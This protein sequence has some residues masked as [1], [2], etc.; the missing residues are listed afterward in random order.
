MLKKTPVLDLLKD[1]DTEKLSVLLIWI[2]FS[3]VAILLLTAAFYSLQFGS[4]LSTDHTRWSEFGSFFGG[5]LGPVLNLLALVALV[6]T[7][8]LQ[9]HQLRYAKHELKMFT[10]QLERAADA[11]ESAAQVFEEQAEISKRAASIATLAEAFKIISE[12]VHQ[13]QE[14]IQA[15]DSEKYEQ[16][17]SEKERLA[18]EILRRVQE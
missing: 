10:E 9:A 16:A 1:I 17:V 5:L 18:G 2:I 15:I 12:V 6:F 4:S 11:Q 8:G 3:A 14:S 7:V 13:Y